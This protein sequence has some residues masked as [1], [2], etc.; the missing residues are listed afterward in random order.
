MNKTIRCLLFLSAIAVVAP[1]HA[2]TTVDVGT[3]A[4][5]PNMPGQTIDIFASGPDLI[6]GMDLF[7]R[8]ADGGPDPD[9]PAFARGVISGPVITDLDILTGT[10]FGSNNTGSINGFATEENTFPDP[11]E[12]Y[13][14]RSTTTASGAVIANGKIGTLTIDTTGFFVGSGPFALVLS[15]TAAGDTIFIDFFSSVGAK[16]PSSITDGLIVIAEVP[17]PGSLALALVALFATSS[18]ALLR[19]HAFC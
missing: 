8:I 17:E 3:H 14:N 16:V 19:R 6:A 15:S 2:L 13:E 5:L 7:V 4:L 12:Q 10:V 9:L 11:Y 1:A 18:I